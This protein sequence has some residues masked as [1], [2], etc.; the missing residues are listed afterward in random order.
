MKTIISALVALVVGAGGMYF[1]L[2]GPMKELQATAVTLE[3]QLTEAKSAAESSAAEVTK[4]QEAGKTLRKR[5]ISR[6]PFRRRLPNSKQRWLQPRRA[7]ARP[8][9]RRYDCT[10]RTPG[11]ACAG[12]VSIDEPLMRQVAR[13]CTDRVLIS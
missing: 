5:Q 12:P 7:R 11:P 2:Q 8:N 6:M 9:N 1:Y 4:L 3:T 13:V 10:K